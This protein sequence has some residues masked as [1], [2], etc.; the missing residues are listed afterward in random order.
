MI[1][2]STYALIERAVDAICQLAEAA[3]KANELTQEVLDHQALSLANM[4]Q[5]KKSSQQLE[6]LL[7]EPIDDDYPV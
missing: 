4:E 2:D 1:D 6:L 3:H 5:L 7:M